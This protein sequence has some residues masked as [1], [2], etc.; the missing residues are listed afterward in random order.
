ML[1]GLSM[2]RTAASDD[3]KDGLTDRNSNS[4]LSNRESKQSV[5]NSKSSGENLI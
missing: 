3:D 5:E 2:S 4:N 1:K